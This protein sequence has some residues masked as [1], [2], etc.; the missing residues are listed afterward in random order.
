M[1]ISFLSDFI[2]PAVQDPG[3]LKISTIDITGKFINNAGSGKLFVITGSAKNGYDGPRALVKIDGKLYSKGKKLVKSETVFAGNSL[4][5]DQLTNMDIAA[6][7]KR[8]KN[9]AG[10]KKSNLKI[11]PGRVVPFMIVFSGLPENLEEYTIEVVES[12]P[13]A[14]K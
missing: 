14:K 12:F 3:N 6:I 9:R 2:K 5:D 8:L 4:T 1:K 7:K 13:A 11:I 10:D